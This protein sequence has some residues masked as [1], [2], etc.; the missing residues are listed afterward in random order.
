MKKEV[1][2]QNGD[3]IKMNRLERPQLLIGEDGNPEVLYCAG[4]LVNVNTRQDG[5][6]FNVHIPLISQ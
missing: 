2:L 1:L 6:S 4:A 5:T 3:T